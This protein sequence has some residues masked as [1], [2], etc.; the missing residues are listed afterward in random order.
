MTLFRALWMFERLLHTCSSLS[1]SAALPLSL[2]SFGF[3]DSM[4]IMLTRSRLEM[5]LPGMLLG[6][7]YDSAMLCYAVGESSPFVIEHLLLSACL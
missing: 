3:S 1:E 2:I 4:G 5:D 7:Y 6:D